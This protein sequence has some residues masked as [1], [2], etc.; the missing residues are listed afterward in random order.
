M[1]TKH[2]HHISSHLITQP[3]LK[4]ILSTRQRFF[5]MARFLIAKSIL[6]P[7]SGEGFLGSKLADAKRAGTGGCTNPTLQTW[8]PYPILRTRLCQGTREKYSFDQKQIR[9]EEL[10]LLVKSPLKPHI[11]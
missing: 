4:G 5:G 7:S 9:I 2:T 11:L 10:E 1:I 6:L 8:V 3:C